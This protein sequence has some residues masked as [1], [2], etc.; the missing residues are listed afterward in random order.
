MTVVLNQAIEAEDEMDARYA[1]EVFENLLIVVRS[2][3]LHILISGILFTVQKPERYPP[4]LRRTLCKYQSRRRISRN[5]PLVPFHRNQIVPI[6]QY[7]TF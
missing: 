3:K 7:E 1:F 6:P 5:G 4:I 2:E